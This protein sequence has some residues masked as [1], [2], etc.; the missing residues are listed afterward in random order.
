MIQSTSQQQLKKKQCSS[1]L[2]TCGD[3]TS[4]C[5]TPSLSPIKNEPLIIIDTT[6]RHETSTPV[7][8][9]MPAIARH[10]PLLR[11]S[12]TNSSGQSLSQK[13]KSQTS[14]DDSSLR[15]FERHELSAGHATLMTTNDQDEIKS[16][17]NPSPTHISPPKTT[18][19][20]SYFVTVG[21]GISKQLEKPTSSSSSSSSSSSNED[22]ALPGQHIGGLEFF[23]NG[24]QQADTSA[25][26]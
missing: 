25:R 6:N 3:K 11:S 20:W 9:A 2:S 16:I 18:A 24:K 23:I 17:E 10:S 8:L 21:E 15:S 13:Q 12:A 5:S 26:K 22:D 19:D 1:P 7:F 4:A 14:S